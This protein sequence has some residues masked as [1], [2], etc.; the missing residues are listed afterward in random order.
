MKDMDVSLQKQY[1]LLRLIVQKMEIVTEEDKRDEGV[2]CAVSLEKIHGTG[3]SF[4]APFI[5]KTIVRQNAI[6]SHWKKSA[7]KAVESK[8]TEKCDK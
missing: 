7:N 5:R 3:S 2:H 6:V 4:M 1:D 8:S